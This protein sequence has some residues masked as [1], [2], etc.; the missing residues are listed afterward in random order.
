[1]NSINKSSIPHI[2]IISTPLVL[3]K[4]DHSELPWDRI[5]L[6]LKK[7]VLGLLQPHGLLSTIRAT[8]MVATVVRQLKS[9]LMLLMTWY[10]FKNVC[11]H[12]STKVQ[13]LC[14][15]VE[16]GVQYHGSSQTI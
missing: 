8:R 6:A 15:P 9:T 1:M 4:W 3:Q 13:A 16:K 14:Q 11:N 5:F 12:T 2:F 10:R 7:N